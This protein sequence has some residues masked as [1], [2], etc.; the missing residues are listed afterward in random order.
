MMKRSLLFLAA[1]ITWLGVAGIELFQNGD[2]KQA[3]ICMAV[4]FFAALL[5]IGWSA[6]RRI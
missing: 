4:A 1:S 2:R 6:L 5:E 3:V